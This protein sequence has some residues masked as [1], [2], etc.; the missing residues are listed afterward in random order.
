MEMV[1]RVGKVLQWLQRA[2]PYL[3]FLPRLS[4]GLVFARTGYGKLTHLERTADFFRELGI[5]APEMQ[6]IFIGGL[7]LVGGA[8]LV[9]GL[10]TRVV[11]IPLAGTMV[12]AILTALLP[13]VSGALDL[14]ALDE[15]LYLF[16]F[17]WL[18]VRGPGSLSADHLLVR[19]VPTLRPF[20]DSRRPQELPA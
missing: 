15:T 1:T 17:G 8:C 2:E 14:L 18:V 7:E 4:L 16:L 11:S 6:A 9:L 5:P 19:V 3:A 10:L 12:V 20:R 13:E